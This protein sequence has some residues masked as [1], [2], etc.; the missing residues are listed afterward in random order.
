M[1]KYLLI[2]LL[3][4]S[5]ALQAA[6]TITDSRGPQT[7]QTVPQR[8][9]SLNWTLTEQLLEL[10]TKPLAMT[11]QAGYSIW[12][13]QPALPAGIE[14]LGSRSEPNLEK[15]IQ[16]KPDL[17]LINEVHSSLLPRLEKIAPVIYFKTFSA[18]HSNPLAAI[19]VYRQLA[20]LLGKEALAESRLQEMNHT[21]S[22]LRQQLEKAYPEQLP[23]VTTVRFSNPSSVY[24]YGDNSM[25]QYALEQLGITS[26]LPQPN[27]QWGLVQ[28]RVLDL[29]KIQQGTVLYFEPFAQWPKLEASRLWQAMPFV[30]KGR[31]RAVPL[32]GHTEVPFH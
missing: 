23:L 17:I 4:F 26:A 25:S 2:G 28:K 13:R 18:D 1:L 19:D 3:S 30:R 11:D 32:P 10:N 5:S 9:A 20:H 15:L 29:S 8:I 22:R 14:E 24:I 6:I 27:S 16:L 7:F 31:I 12:V 21:F